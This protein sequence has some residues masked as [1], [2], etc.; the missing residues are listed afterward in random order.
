MEPLVS[1]DTIREQEEHAENLLQME[2][3]KRASSVIA[4]TVD[5]EVKQL[6][7]SLGHPICLFG[8]SKNDRRH[9][10]R[11]LLAERELLG[12]SDAKVK[13][14]L[15]KL[16]EVA[17]KRDSAVGL[18]GE[19]VFYT[20]AMKELVQARKSIAAFS[21]RQTS[22]RM[23]ASG[24]LVE[25]LM[26]GEETIGQ[27]YGNC[28]QM[29][30]QSSQFSDTRRPMTSCKISTCGRFV[31]TSSSAEVVSV[32]RRDDCSQL[33]ECIGHTGRVFDVS[34]HPSTSSFQSVPHSTEAKSSG[35]QLLLASASFDQ[36]CLLWPLTTDLWDSAGEP[37]KIQPARRL[38]GHKNR[39]SK[40]C[41]HPKG[42]HVLTSSYDYT[43][44]LWDATTGQQLLLQDGHD[45]GNF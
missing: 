1:E 24:V 41:W 44:R 39:L 43:W 13:Q 35:S 19:E 4:P 6:L 14:E 36:T 26:K 33:V 16:K 15:S 23:R 38:S 10:L 3:T 27:L 28:R 2:I 32:W 18:K 31:V 45:S 42:D 22:K 5:E 37:G 11:R 9:R 25:V 30:L 34:I 8:E 21:W 7:R 12:E 29:M 17:A 40:V 20:A